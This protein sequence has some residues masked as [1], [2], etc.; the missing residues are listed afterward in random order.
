MNRETRLRAEEAARILGSEVFLSVF[1]AVDKEIVARWRSGTDPDRREECFYQQAALESV[2]SRLIEHITA[3][4][5]AEFRDEGKPG[6][7]RALWEKLW[8]ERDEP[9]VRRN[10]GERR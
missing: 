5:E 1:A 2:W 7:W 10:V 6:Y 9:S 8:S 3:A 4:A